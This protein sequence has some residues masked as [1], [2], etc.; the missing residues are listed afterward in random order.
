MQLSGERSGINFSGRVTRRRAF[1]HL[2]DSNKLCNSSWFEASQTLY[3]AHVPACWT[4][5][6][7]KPLFG[8]SQS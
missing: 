4:E 6:E 7:L 1:S 3:A 5:K 2:P 8:M